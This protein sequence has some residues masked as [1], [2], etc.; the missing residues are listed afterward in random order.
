MDERWSPTNSCLFE[1]K[2][3]GHLWAQVPAIHLLDGILLP[4]A[5][6]DETED[7]L[8]TNNQPD[9]PDETHIPDETLQDVPGIFEYTTLSQFQDT[10]SM[11]TQ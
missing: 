10:H 8:D 3:F 7:E 2:V 4:P 5:I 9:I 1:V 6:D 11:D